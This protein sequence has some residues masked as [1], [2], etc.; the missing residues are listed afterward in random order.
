MPPETYNQKHTPSRTTL[1]ELVDSSPQESAR[2]SH[3][4]HRVVLNGRGR[5]PLVIEP[6]TTAVIDSTIWKLLRTGLFSPSVEGLSDATRA[7]QADKVQRFVRWLDAQNGDDPDNDSILRKHSNHEINDKGLKTNA[8]TIAVIG[9]LRHAQRNRESP[10]SSEEYAKA[11]RLS[12][13]V[14]PI[15]N[16]GPAPSVCDWFLDIPWLRQAMTSLGLEN[17]YLKLES[18][19]MVLQSLHVLYGTVLDEIMR[20]RCACLAHETPTARQVETDKRLATMTEKDPGA[21]S[22]LRDAKLDQFQWFMQIVS[23]MDREHP[24]RELFFASRFGKDAAEANHQSA[25]DPIEYSDNEFATNINPKSIQSP[26]ILNRAHLF[27]PTVLEQVIVTQLIASLA[28]Q[29][30]YASR[31]KIEN[32]VILR[33]SSGRPQSMQFVYRK[34]RSGGQTKRTV[35]VS[36]SS[37]IGRALIGYVQVIE[38]AQSMLPKSERN[39]LTPTFAHKKMLL[40]L[41]IPA[42]G[43]SVSPVNLLV[44]WLTQPGM[45]HAV[46][47]QFAREGSSSVLLDAF[48]TVLTSA[49]H[50]TPQAQRLF[51]KIEYAKGRVLPKSLWSCMALKQL[52]VYG[53][54]D[55][56]RVGDLRNVNSHTSETERLSYLTDRNKDWVNRNGRIT[57]IV[58]NDLEQHVFGHNVDGVHKA[59]YERMLRTEIVN[60]LD[61]DK[62]LVDLQIG[63]IRPDTLAADSRL[64]KNDL[65]NIVVIDHPTTVVYLLHYLDQAESRSRHLALN[66]PEFFE[67]TVAPLCEWME[68]LLTEHLSPDSVRKGRIEYD[69]VK[70]FLPSIFEHQLDN[71]VVARQC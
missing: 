50:S 47:R 46:T 2:I 32:A 66:V 68:Q 5:N 53:R 37:I 28:V 40:P 22:E 56:Y 1:R 48:L 12:C 42:S 52:G 18:P 24:G 21:R 6:T 26:K 55:R 59:S 36:A 25:Y 34:T 29:P 71:S 63:S 58:I 57:R 65:N 4:R 15:C 67:Y 17:Q 54:S 39:Y 51:G 9:V 45:R 38:R 11:E 60:A 27:L 41:G 16:G 30:T 3:G 62:N 23:R 31:L 10:L 7:G 70:A 19:K 8:Q 49:D 33:S 43:G 64:A 13:S 20:F 35:N 69:K 61:T 14:I 44:Y